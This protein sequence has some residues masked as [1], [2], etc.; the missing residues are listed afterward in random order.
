MAV[1]ILHVI[2]SYIPAWRYGGTVKAV[3]ELCRGLVRLGEE[4][5]IFTTNVDGPQDLPVPLAEPVFIDGVEVRY[6][7]VQPPRSYSFSWPFT[8][9]LR[10][11]IP[12]FDLV[13]VHSL[14]NYLLTPTAFLCRRRGV[15][16]IVTPWGMLDSYALRKSPWKK[17]IYGLLLERRNLR[18]ARAIHFGS[19]EEQRRA[20]V[21]NLQVPTFIAPSGLDL[22]EFAMLPPLGAFRR[23][24]PETVGKRLILFLGRLGWIKGLDLLIR[25]FGL[26]AQEQDDVHLAIVGPEDGRFQGYG[27]K[28]RQRLHEEGV[29]H[30]TTFTGMLVGETKLAALRDSDLFVLPS[31]SENFGMAALEAMAC[32]VPV[33]VSREVGLAADIGEAGAGLVVNCDALELAQAMGRLLDD[34]LLRQEMGERGRRLV[35]ERFRSDHVAARM[36]EIYRRILNGGPLP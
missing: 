11:E 4:V 25:A 35:S 7:Q 9:A 10:R 33:V 31:Y 22:A 6:F 29:L 3:S 27:A 5:T 19:A 23:R 26:L 28:L 16:Y 30:R 12:S 17:R 24:Y 1:K 18:G 21:F 15:P 14:F 36:V 13:H 8:M 32:G 2:P 34:P 20:F